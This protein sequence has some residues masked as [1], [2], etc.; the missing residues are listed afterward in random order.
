MWTVICHFY[1][2]EYLLPWWLAHH[3]IIFDHGI[4]IDYNSTDASR[5]IINQFCPKWEIY[6]TRN[7]Y[8]D[9]AAIDRE[10]EDFEAGCTSWRMALNV[11]EFL[12]GNSAQLNAVTAPTQHFIGNYVFVDPRNG[13]APTYQR[14]LHEQ[15][16]FGYYED[17]RQ[18]TS[19]LNLGLRASRSLHNYAIQYPEKGGRHWPQEPTLRDLAIF[20]YGYA[21]TDEKG[22]ARKLQIKEKMSPEERRVHGGQH[23]NAVSRDRFLSNIELYH[24]P[25]CSDLSREIARLA[26]YQNYGELS[27]APDPA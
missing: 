15:F 25:R 20:Y 6:N 9:S 27:L 18:A 16:T 26:E 11:T 14:A 24:R 1:N 17:D 21:V 8:F 7:A 4:M 13:E 23:P 10:V 2:E 3:R 5:A 19:K 22:I 12:Y